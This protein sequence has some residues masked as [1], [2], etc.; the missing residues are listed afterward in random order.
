MYL[1]K[2]FPSLFTCK[3]HAEQSHVNNGLMTFI[4]PD[5][6]FEAFKNATKVNKQGK[7]TKIEYILWSMKIF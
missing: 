4:Q 7:S 5:L 1:L 2:Q 3:G 6:F